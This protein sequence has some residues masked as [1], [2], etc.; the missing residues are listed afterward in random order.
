MTRR[1]RYEGE[2]P[3]NAPPR[4]DPAEHNIVLRVVGGRGPKGFL[5][6]AGFSWGSLAGE[7]VIAVAAIF[8]AVR[9]PAVE[10]MIVMLGAMLA[11]AAIVLGTQMVKAWSERMWSESESE[12]SPVRRRRN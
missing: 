11:I 2:I 7:A 9:L 3:T 4:A 5:I 6:E 10:A 8:T 12:S 1:G